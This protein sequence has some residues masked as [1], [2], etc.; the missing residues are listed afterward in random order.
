MVVNIVIPETRWFEFT[1]PGVDGVHRLPMQ[2]GLSKKLARAYAAVPAAPDPDTAA[3]DWM[4]KVFST[5]CPE[6][7]LDDMPMSVTRALMEA[8]TSSSETDLGESPSSSDSATS[9]PQQSTTISSLAPDTP[10]QI[11]Q[12]A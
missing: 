2:E 10:S 8:W 4:D 11:S 6:L 1:L 5:Y 12:T 7:N 3:M 9:T